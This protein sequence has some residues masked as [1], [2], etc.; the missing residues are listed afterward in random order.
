MVGRPAPNP[1]LWLFPDYFSV[2]AATTVARRRDNK[3]VAGL[4][5]KNRAPQG[6]RFQCAG[7]GAD[8][9]VQRGTCCAPASSGRI[10]PAL[11]L[12]NYAARS[13]TQQRRTSHVCHV[14]I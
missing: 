13:A 12:F 9:I 5:K 3:M 4:S 1:F 2:I 10:H 14:E 6:T 7:V 11:Q 8:N